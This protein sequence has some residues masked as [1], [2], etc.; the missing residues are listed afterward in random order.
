MLMVHGLIGSLGY[1]E[2]G[3]RIGGE[4]VR[5]ID[6]VG[7]GTLPLARGQRPTLQRQA[8]HVVGSAV[9]GRWS[10][11]SIFAMK[12]RVLIAHTFSI[13]E[14]HPT[15]ARLVLSREKPGGFN[16]KLKVLPINWFYGGKE[17]ADNPY[18]PKAF[19]QGKP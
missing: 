14:D 15:E 19:E 6:L 11:P 7:Y 12:D 16:Q 3:Q 1:F 4:V 9:H 17:P 18:L 8:E 10:Y 5:P 13:Y 2:P